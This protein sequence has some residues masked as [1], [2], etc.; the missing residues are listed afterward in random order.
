MSAKSA[1]ITRLTPPELAHLL[2][3]SARQKITEAQVVQ[4]AEAAGI[5]QPD[6]TIN[7]IEYTA[8]LISEVSRGAH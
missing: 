8:I 6:G 4:I 1:Q 3:I 5:C 2:S 7:L